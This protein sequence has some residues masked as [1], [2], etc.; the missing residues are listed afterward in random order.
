MTN[1]KDRMQKKD[2]VDIITG[3]RAK[4]KWKPYKFTK[5]T[6]FVSLLKDVP[7]GCKQKVLPEPLSK[8]HTVLILREKRDSPT[9]KVSVCLEH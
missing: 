9:M 6:V 3:G 5:L 8:N 2:I 4:T 1:L 7:M